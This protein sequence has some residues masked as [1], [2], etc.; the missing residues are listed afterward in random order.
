M[1]AG[2]QSFRTHRLLYSNDSYPNSDNLNGRTQLM[3]VCNRSADRF[4]PVPTF[5]D[6]QN[7]GEITKY[8]ALVREQLSIV[9]YEKLVKSQASKIQVKFCCANL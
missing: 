2:I 1:P 5:S 4:V 7:P 9:E 6:D 8:L 3:S